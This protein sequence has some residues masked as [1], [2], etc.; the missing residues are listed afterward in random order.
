MVERKTLTLGPEWPIPPGY[1]R[2]AEVRYAADGE[3]VWKFAP[4]GQWVEN[5]N[6]ASPRIVLK[7]Q[8]LPNFPNW[9]NEGH[10]VSVDAGGEI[11]LWSDK[12]SWLANSGQWALRDKTKDD[13]V[14]LNTYSQAYRLNQIFVR[15]DWRFPDGVEPAQ[16]CWQ[17]VTMMDVQEIRR[18]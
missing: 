5:A 12:P 10:W 7:K 14:K 2:E 3:L 18:P 17:K 9:M 1:T 15:H 13:S 4:I 6:S 11:W 8:P 16:C